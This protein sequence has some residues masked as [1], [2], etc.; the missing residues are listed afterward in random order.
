LDGSSDASA[1]AGGSIYVRAGTLTIDSSTISANSSAQE[2]G[3]TIAL[4]G[5]QELTIANGG[6]VLAQTTSLGHG[7]NIT[8]Q[9]GSLTIQNGQISAG[10]TGS[11]NGGNV[12]VDVAGALTITGDPESPFFTGISAVT[13]S[14]GDAGQVAIRARGITLT[15]SGQITSS[16]F[17][18]GN[19]GTVVVDVAGALTITG[20]P[21]SPFFTGISA[22][23]VSTGDAGQVAIKA[24]SITLT[25]SG[26]I[27]SSTFGSGNGGKVTVES[28]GAIEIHGSADAVGGTGIAADSLLGA[29]GDAGT[30]TV[31]AGSVTIDA[32][33]QIS[34][35]TSGPGNGGDITV[36]VAGA[37]AITGDPESDFSTGI[38]ANSQPGATGDAGRVTVNAGTATIDSTGEVSSNTYGPGNGGDVTVNVFDALAITGDPDSGLRT[39]IAADSRHGA[40]GDAG[41]VAVT[42]GSVTINDTGQISSNTFG[43]GKGGDVTVN[44]AGEIAITGDPESEFF[45]G[46][47]AGAESVG[48]AGQVTVGASSVSIADNAQ[49]ASSTSGSGNGGNVTVDVRGALQIQGNPNAFGPTGIAADSLP[50]AMGSAGQ[51]TVQADRVSVTDNGQISTNS[52]GAGVAGDILIKAQHVVI[53]NG[54]VTSDTAGTGASGSA[55]INSASI[56][57][58]NGAVVSA[59]ATGGGES[60]DVV[61]SANAITIDSSVVSTESVSRGGGS[62]EI[63]ASGLLYITQGVVST[64]VLNGELDAG[65]ITI[66]ADLVV[67]DG[68]WVGADASGGRGGNLHLMARGLVAS[69][70]SIIWAS[71]DIVVLVQSSDVTSGLVELSDVLVQ[72]ASRLACTVAPSGPQDPFSSVIVHG[73]GEYDFD[74]DAPGTASY[75]AALVAADQTAQSGRGEVARAGQSGCSP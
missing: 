39:G 17:G 50:G 63:T 36:N 60:G 43:S 26:Q 46:I 6:Y 23:T 59:K 16:T 70:N 75:G 71:S 12:V 10:T 27:T 62:I 31:D 3:G 65:N 8:V 9:A 66:N 29:T 47:S 2:S 30:V 34:T 68:S 40:T 20:N 21:E 5:E 33:G 37:L 61:L 48:D 57:V 64:Y 38:G 15:N 52:S 53:D 56:L 13:V 49:I 74:P 44:A 1:S 4:V 24:R 42:A 51:I 55:V 54:T 32:T 35:N 19:G 45:T 41:K 72:D 14:T 7:G 25:D 73:R 22:V 11:G 69:T 28:T 18:F 58:T 67:L